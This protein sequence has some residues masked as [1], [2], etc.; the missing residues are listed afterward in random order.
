[1]SESL[2]KNGPG[3]SGESAEPVEALGLSGPDMGADAGTAGDR[4]A[5]PNSIDA[6]DEAYGTEARVMLKSVRLPEDGP[7]EA[8]QVRE[9]VGIVRGHIKAHRITLTTISHAIGVSESAVSET[10]RSKY[11]GD[12]ESIIRKLNSWVDD[13]ERRRKRTAPIGIYETGVLISV[14]DAAAIAKKNARTAAS[15]SIHGGGE[16]IVM[17]I[18]PSGIGKSAAAEALAAADPN[19]ILVRIAEHA[20]TGAALFDGI[21]ASAG[22]RVTGP[23]RSRA[24]YVVDRLNNSGRL[25]IVD[26]FHRAKQS[27]YDQVRDLAEVCGIPVLLLGTSRMARR[28][29]EPRSGVGRGLLDEQFSRRVA[30]VVDL[31]RGSDGQGGVRRPFFSIDEIVAIFKADK[32]RLTHDGAEYLAAVACCIGVGMLGQASNIFEKAAFAARRRNGLIDAPLLRMATEKV[33]MP[34]GVRNDEIMRQI[35]TTLAGNRKLIA[36]AG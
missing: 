12:R 30:Y 21:I 25:L 3:E 28:V 1:M 16:R 36:A 32:V 18:G 19:A 20:R 7:L 26:E 29:D 15:K 33:L 5:P 6:V 2:P 24:E 17:A 10:L 14:R 27:A 35:D 9:V 11:K 22:W 8:D 31:L 23:R 4:C 34:V 13:D